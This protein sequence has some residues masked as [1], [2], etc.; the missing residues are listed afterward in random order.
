MTPWNLPYPKNNQSL[1]KNI[2]ENDREKIGSLNRRNMLK[3]KGNGK[4]PNEILAWSP[5]I[6]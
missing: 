5:L 1:S 2:V 4:F 3:E 6:N